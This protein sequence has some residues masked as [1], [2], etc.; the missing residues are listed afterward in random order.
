[1]HLLK[2][3]QKILELWSSYNR[4]DKETFQKKWLDA[5]QQAK[6]T[7]KPW[8]QTKTWGEHEVDY[9]LAEEWLE[10]LNKYAGLWRA[11][12]RSVCAGH[13]HGISGLGVLAI[14][15]ATGPCFGVVCSS[16]RDAFRFA[17]LLSIRETFIEVRLDYTRLYPD[18]T[19]RVRPEGCTQVKIKWNY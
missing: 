10:K 13:P 4:P 8:L 12:V 17:S 14:K 3:E 19:V 7:G 2:S 11:N 15:H 9:E 6:A 1:M 5:L 16:E 18:Y